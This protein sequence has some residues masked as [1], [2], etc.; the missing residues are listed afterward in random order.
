[1][2]T[3]FPW[4]LHLVVYLH[5]P[6]AD[7]RENG[8]H[9]DNPLCQTLHFT[10]SSADSCVLLSRENHSRHRGEVQRQQI[11]LDLLAQQYFGTV[12]G[13]R[14][15]RGV[16]FHIMM[17]W[18][19]DGVVLTTLRIWSWRLCPLA[20]T[21][22]SAKYWTPYSLT[23]TTH[24]RPSGHANPVAEKGNSLLEELC[25]T[26]KVDIKMRTVKILGHW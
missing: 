3:W 7:L 23:P 8:P 10:R 11:L 6:H 19:Y 15:R 21:L 16:P 4:T 25:R 24:H 26:L 13:W 1:M 20:V 22:T 18:L 2:E 12:S 5:H 17:G 14:L 9:M